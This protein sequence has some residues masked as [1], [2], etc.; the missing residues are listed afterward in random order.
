MLWYVAVVSHRFL[1]GYPIA[2]FVV[3]Y[4]LVSWDPVLWSCGVKSLDMSG[5]MAEVRDYDYAACHFLSTVSKGL[6]NP[7]VAVCLFVS[8]FLVPLRFR[9]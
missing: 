3:L 9:Q 4:P 6:A 7:S 1:C 8:Y 5:G 2:P